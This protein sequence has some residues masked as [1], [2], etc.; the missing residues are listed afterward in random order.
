MGTSRNP[1]ELAGK[2]GRLIGDL[3]RGDLTREAVEAAAVEYKQAGLLAYRRATGGDLKLSGVGR[4]GARLGVRYSEP[5]GTT[6]VATVVR[7]TG[8][9]HLI[10]HAT[11]PHRIPRERGRRARRRV[12][13]IPGVG[14]RAYANHPGKPANPTFH[15]AMR[16]RRPRAMRAFVIRI[17]KG[18]RRRFK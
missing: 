11:K 3:E 6:N 18:M 16:L 10:D 14:V 15:P 4:S 13:V 5:T 9:A 1:A 2:F 7:V 12:V 17:D 8:P